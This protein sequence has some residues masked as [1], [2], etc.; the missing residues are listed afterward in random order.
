MRWSDPWHV[1]AFGF[2]A[3]LAPKAPGTV[4]TLVGIPVHLALVGLP[5]S[6]HL[7][8]IALLAVAGIAICDRAARD[9][10]VPDHPG[11]VWDEIVGYL[12]TMLA[13]P[14]GWP[15][16]VAGFTLFRLFDIFKPWPVS[17]ADRRVHGGLGIMLDDLL[18]GGYAAACLAL[19]ATAVGRT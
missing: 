15:W 14:P 16:L 18:A 9:L 12:L 17:I 10:G 6:T 7:A 3:G 5:W 11:I 8:V 1:L 13:A 19:L 2:G 4:G